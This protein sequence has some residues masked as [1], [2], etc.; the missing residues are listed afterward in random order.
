MRLQGFLEGI[1][2]GTPVWTAEERQ[3]IEDMERVTGRPLTEPEKRIAVA[4]ARMIG[5]L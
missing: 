2:D 1:P 3:L 4:Q 5:Y